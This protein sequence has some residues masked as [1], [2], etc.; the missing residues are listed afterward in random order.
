M[1][2]TDFKNVIVENV[3]QALFEIAWH[4]F[5]NIENKNDKNSKWKFIKTR[6]PNLSAILSEKTGAS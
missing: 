6:L 5:W 3:S 2:S 4:G 1:E